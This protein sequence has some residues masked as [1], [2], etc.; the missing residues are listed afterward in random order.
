MQHHAQQRSLV[1]ERPETSLKLK[2]ILM[3]HVETLPEQKSTKKG[4]SALA[5]LQNVSQLDFAHIGLAS[6]F[7]NRYFFDPGPSNTVGPLLYNELEVSKTFFS[8]GGSI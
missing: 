2:Q 7:G 3:Q 8:C 1:R 6:C 4:G 5:G